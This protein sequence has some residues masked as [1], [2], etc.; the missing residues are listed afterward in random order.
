MTQNPEPEVPLL[1]PSLI[2]KW[3]GKRFLPP[4]GG[5][6][7]TVSLDLLAFGMFLPDLQLR[8]KSLG[9]VG[10][11]LGLVLSIYSVA[12]I[13]A[14]PIMGKLSD[15][16]GR[17]L[18]LL[19]SSSVSTIA[20]LFYARSGGIDGLAFLILSRIFL[21]LGG[22]NLGTAFAYVA[23][24]TT[25]KNRSAGMGLV[26][27]G[28]G[29]GFVLG[30]VFG[31][32]LLAIGHGQ[33]VL[34]G[35]VGAILTFLN[36]LYI[37]IFLP[38]PVREKVTASTVNGWKS[39]KAAFQ[40]RD[41][42]VLLIMFFALNLGFTNLEST[43]FLLLASH[44]S[45]FHLDPNQARTIGSYALA[46]V[47]LISVIMQG[48]LTKILTRKFGEL[49]IL[50]VAFFAEACAFIFLPRAPLWIPA[51]LAL[52]VLSISTGASSPNS[53]SLVSKSSPPSMQGSIFGI[54]QGIGSMARLIGPSLATWLFAINV[55]L[56]YD[57]GAFLL[58][59]GALIALTIK[60]RDFETSPE[61]TI[62]EPA[63]ASL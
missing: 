51:I 15:T 43:F 2:E 9:L 5:I 56:P 50:R 36:V 17:R 37:L 20:Y 34:L 33:P 55:T 31:G 18:I 21:G 49:K 53:Q 57:L 10:I 48:F 39:Y 32:V 14:S 1:E 6:F 54:T 61:M 35:I 27:A 24:I 45:V 23:D 19:I 7:L 42:A 52:L 59:V 30:P 11:Q 13:I 12:Q 38:E 22:G 60:P 41:L 29:I 16:Y 58:L 26:G 44:R 63:V 3:G 40:N 8:G 25:E 62:A 47:G 46:F 28:F 4:L